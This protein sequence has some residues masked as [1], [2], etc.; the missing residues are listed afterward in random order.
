MFKI[1]HFH[2]SKTIVFRTFKKTMKIQME[3]KIKYRCL[4]IFPMLI[5]CRVEYVTQIVNI[6]ELGIIQFEFSIW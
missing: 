4:T 2:V 1:L 5:T 3:N 6:I